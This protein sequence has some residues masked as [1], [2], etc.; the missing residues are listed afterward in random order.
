MPSH[1]SPSE[2][3]WTLPVWEFRPGAP[4][5]FALASSLFFSVAPPARACLP[6]PAARPA[7]PQIL[8]AGGGLF[9]MQIFHVMEFLQGR[10]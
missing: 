8:A 3:G 7:E 9:T 1:G 6:A 5:G 2:A 10:K 4:G